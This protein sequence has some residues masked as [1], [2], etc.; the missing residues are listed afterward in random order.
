VTRRI[1]ILVALLLL[2]ASILVALGS[3]LAGRYY[4]G[5]LAQTASP[6]TASPSS[7]AENPVLGVPTQPR[8]HPIP[9]GASKDLNVTQRTTGYGERSTSL[10]ETTSLED[11]LSSP[12]KSTLS[13][14]GEVARSPASASYCWGGGCADGVWT[15]PPRKQTLYVP[16]GAEMVFRFGGQGPPNK[17][18]ASATEL[19]GRVDTN[20][21]G[22]GR[23]YSLKASGSGV[24]RVIRARLPPDEYLVD[25]HITAPQGDVPYIFRVVV[26]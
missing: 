4:Y 2:A 24:K 7:E 17:V 25:V 22:L 11:Y 26:Q 1:G 18:S 14:G 23:A 6:Q 16:S 13:Y 8:S 3:M 20:G 15:V 9:A 21:G 5:T 19:L 12:P 10:E